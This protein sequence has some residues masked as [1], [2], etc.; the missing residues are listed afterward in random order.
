MSVYGYSIAKGKTRFNVNLTSSQTNDRI[1]AIFDSFYTINLRG[2]L[3]STDF[4]KEYNVYLTFESEAS[5]SLLD[6]ALIYAIHLELGGNKINSYS[7]QDL[8]LPHFIAFKS[9]Y[10]DSGGTAVVRFDTKPSDN[11]PIRVKSLY[12]LD[13]IG[14]NLFNA[15]T[16]ETYENTLNYQATL[17]FEEV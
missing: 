11:A 16:N 1:G 17:S 5:S 4:Q 6:P 15:T 7:S 2:H 3:D 10:N 8:R 13:K 14:F 9:I 12:G